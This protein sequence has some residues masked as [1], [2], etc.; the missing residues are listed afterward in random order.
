MVELGILS[1]DAWSIDQ[2]KG[3]DRSVKFLIGN[4]R[5]RQVI[6]IMKPSV[7]NGLLLMR[8]GAHVALWPVGPNDTPG[9]FDELHEHNGQT[10]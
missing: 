3:F 2:V 9:L 5:A 7:P 6:Q 10:R 8:G 4:P 1:A